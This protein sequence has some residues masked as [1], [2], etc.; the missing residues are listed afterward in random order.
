[1]WKQTIF[2]PFFY[3]SLYGRGT[4]L[5]PVTESPCYSS[6]DFEQVPVL[7]TAAVEDSE[8]K[9]LTL[10]LLNRDM[11]EGLATDIVLRGF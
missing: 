4:A 3:T 2:Y 11:N 9:M 5:R 6:R 10:F 7:E 8:G 1:M